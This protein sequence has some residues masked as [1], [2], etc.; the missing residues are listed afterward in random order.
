MVLLFCSSIITQKLGVF[1]IF[2]AFFLGVLLHD[3]KNFVSAWKKQIGTLV[4]VFFVPIFFTFT[5]LRV[6][7]P[8][9]NS[10]QDII[11]LVIIIAVATISKW[12]GCYFAARKTGLEHPMAMALGVFMNTRALME[13]VV[14]NIALDLGVISTKSFSMLVI[15]AIVST[16][17][18]GPILHRL[19]KRY[20]YLQY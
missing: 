10:F 14:A 5:G 6:N 2:G 9:L 13:L 3:Q 17:I 18:T 8:G 11:W 12:G 20:P 7:I 1:A 19:L 16:I 4:M 15:M